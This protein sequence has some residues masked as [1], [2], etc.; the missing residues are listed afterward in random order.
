MK[1][2]KPL[3]IDGLFKLDQERSILVNKNKDDLL[4][5][6]YSKKYSLKNL[7]TSIFWTEKLVGAESSHDP[8][9]DDRVMTV[10]KLIPKE[11]RSILNIGVGDGDLEKNINSLG[12]CRYLRLGLDITREGLVE[13]RKKSDFSPL[14]G[15]ILALPLHSNKFDIVSVLEVLEHLPY[16]QIFSALD[17]IKRVLKPGGILLVSVPVN[18]TYTSDNNPNGHMRRYSVGLILKELELS[19]FKIEHYETL[20]AFSGMYRIKKILARYILKNKWLPNVVI[21]KARLQ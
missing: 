3:T 7:N 1:K 18:E 2:I 6:T 5:Q 15:S 20:F 8:M 14:C 11:S 4:I 16:Y 19:G 9:K 13:A 17:E 12:K 21:I 10:A